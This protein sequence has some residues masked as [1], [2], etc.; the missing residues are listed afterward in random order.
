MNYIVELCER[1]QDRIVR[2]KFR[3][4]DG[5]GYFLKRVMTGMYQKK[6]IYKVD[7]MISDEEKGLIG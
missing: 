1:I 2:K 4:L 5:V 3:I 7:T 6:G